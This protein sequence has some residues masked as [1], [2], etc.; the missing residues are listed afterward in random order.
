MP[1]PS[2]AAR[3]KAARKACH[4][5]VHTFGLRFYRSGRSVE[6]WESGRRVPEPLVLIRLEALEKKI[7]AGALSA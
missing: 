6:A 3:I 1:Q 4:E 5:D 7:A 2:I